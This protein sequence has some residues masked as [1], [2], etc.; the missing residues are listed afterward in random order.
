M[1][2]VFLTRL[3]ISQVPFFDGEITI[4]QVAAGQHFSLGLSHGGDS[5]FS[6]GRGDYGSLGIGPEAKEKPGATFPSPQRVRIPPGVMLKNVA[7]GD[8]TAMVRSFS[9]SL[10]GRRCITSNL[11]IFIE[12]DRQLH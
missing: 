5:L 8:A 6:W 11:S 7:A 4:G 2:D 10:V 1:A 12:I 3:T 9:R